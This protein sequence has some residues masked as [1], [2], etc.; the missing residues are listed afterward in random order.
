[1][2]LKPA[3]A[4]QQVPILSYIVRSYFKKKRKKEKN[5]WGYSSVVECLLSI[6]K[7]LG[8]NSTTTKPTNY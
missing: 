8:S 3:C 4:T 2:S 6:D 7:A 1:M 5:G